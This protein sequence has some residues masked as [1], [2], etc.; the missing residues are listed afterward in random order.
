M[1]GEAGERRRLPARREQ[2]LPSDGPVEAG[3]LN[4]RKREIRREPHDQARR[5][6]VRKTGRGS[7][8]GGQSGPAGNG[9]ACGPPPAACWSFIFLICAATAQALAL[10][11]AFLV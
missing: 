1:R 11:P 6:R 2:Q 9:W 8:R 10:K 4:E 7:R 5:P 3:E